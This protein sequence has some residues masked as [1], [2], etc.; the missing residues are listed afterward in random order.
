MCIYICRE[1]ERE[2]LACFR[3]TPSP[4]ASGARPRPS[5][6]CR[7]TAAGLFGACLS[8]V[9][10]RSPWRWCQSTAVSRR[11]PWR[12]TSRRARRC[13]V[14]RLG[15]PARAAATSWSGG[16]PPDGQAPPSPPEVSRMLLT[17]TARPRAPTAAAAGGPS[18]RSR[19]CAKMQGR[20]GC[21]GGSPGWRSPR[22]PGCA[23]GC[24]A[25]R[26]P[27]PRAEVLRAVSTRWAL[28]LP[29]FAASTPARGKTCS[30]QYLEEHGRQL[31]AGGES[32]STFG[33][34]PQTLVLV[35]ALLQARRP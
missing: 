20:P 21:R 17:P 16:Q 32:T 8:A 14:W 27:G 26:T 18:R 10:R 6:L 24:G 11:S 7:S 33:K 22:T 4:A 31:A 28:R 34:R 15:R 2:S 3:T 25:R 1:R 29:P 5:P 19:P 35:L 9:L 23:R 13:G 30:R 12:W